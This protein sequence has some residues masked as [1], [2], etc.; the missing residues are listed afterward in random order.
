MSLLLAAALLL[1]VQAARAA[2]SGDPFSAATKLLPELFRQK[3]QPGK[4]GPAVGGDSKAAVL[5]K[6]LTDPAAFMVQHTLL[7]Q[8]DAFRAFLA[9]QAQRD[10]FCGHPVVRGILDRPSLVKPLLA[11][12][13][14]VPLC[15]WPLGPRLAEFDSS[16]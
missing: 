14:A 5:R 12:S 4:T 2:D 3:L 1:P 15:D 10:R 9:D 7:G 16:S 6:L 8:P 11:Q 13:R